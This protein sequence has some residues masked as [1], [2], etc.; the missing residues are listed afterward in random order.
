MINET[1]YTNNPL[2]KEQEN[3]IDALFAQ[4]DRNDAPGCAV[5][6]IKD[7]RFIYKKSFG[8]ANLDYDIPITSD[9][10]FELASVSKQF[11]AACIALL[12]LEGKLD[13]DDEVKKYIPEMPVYENILTIKHLI[14]HTSGL[15]DYIAIGKFF[16]IRFENCYNN[17]DGL[18]LICKQK[19]LDFLPGEKYS[20]SNSD[21][22][23]LAEIVNRITGKTIREF[24]DENIFKPLD[25]QNT[26]FNDNYNDII[27]N[28][29]SSYYINEDYIHT[30]RSN[31]MALGSSNV[32][33]T[34]NDLLNWDN[35]FY[36]PKLGGQNF[37]DLILT[38]G[39]LN[40][41]EMI[42]YAFGLRY[43][44]YKGIKN[45][46]HSGGFMGFKTQIKQFTHEKISIIILSNRS[47]FE[48]IDFIDS[49]TDILLADQIGKFSAKSD[50]NNSEQFVANLTEPYNYNLTNLN[51][52]TGSYYCDELDVFYNLQFEMDKLILILDDKNIAE[53]SPFVQDKFIVKKWD[54]YFTFYYN[55]KNE[56]D[57]FKLDSNRAKNI[58]F[59]KQS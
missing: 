11:T 39:K 24:A 18:K 52:Y 32:T 38:R 21:Y 47:D 28:R 14:H 44:A 48:P 56:I 6:V 45:I 12:Y 33:S 40:N 23:L 37:L 22:L 13:L 50:D 31:F 46:T 1:E 34:I 2:T 16:G 3:Q 29:V 54:C 59:I 19:E 17:N 15:R 30:Y 9:S 5:G 35:N 36:A 51:N 8:M 58:K 41:Q 7:G 55:E 20:Y 42:D 53:I 43:D 57:G 25:M 10:K 4:Y 27:K 26:F 49:I